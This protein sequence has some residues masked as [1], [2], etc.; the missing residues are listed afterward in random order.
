MSIAAKRLAAPAIAAM[1]LGLAACGSQ[2]TSGGGGGGQKG[3]IKFALLS[4]RTGPAA[5]LGFDKEYG[6]KAGVALATNGTNEVAGRKIEFVVGDNRSEVGQSPTVARQII[7]RDKPAVVFG[8]DLSDSAVATAP[9][10]RDAKIIDIYTIAATSE[11]SNFSPTTFRTSR[12]S[13]QEAKVG[14]EV[15]KIKQGESFQVLAPDYAYGQATAKAWQKLLTDA[16]GKA[17]GEPLYAPLVANDYTS[18]VQ[19]VKGNNPDKLIVVTFASASGPLLWKTIT[20]AGLDNQMDIYTLLPQTPGRKG[21]GRIATKVKF[22]AIYDPNLLQTDKNKQFIEEFKKL[23]PGGKAPDVYAGDSAVAGQLAVAALKKT[24][25][26]TSP[27]KLRAA[28]EGMK[29]DGIKGPYEV[30]K[31]HILLSNYYAARVKPD[32]SAELVR[33]LPIGVSAIPEVPPKQ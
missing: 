19:R 28:L 30:R 18:V 21:M 15:V 3:P 7:Q 13:T 29:G 5:G 10:M 22:F 25:G 8:F 14:S 2:S 17:A 26:D 4:E 1:L 23:A 32:G 12:D 20:S 24:N 33:E 9:I 27:D 6:V 31:D 16:G 11:L